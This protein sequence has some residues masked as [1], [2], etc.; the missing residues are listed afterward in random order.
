VA[1]ACVTVFDLTLSERVVGRAIAAEGAT[2]TNEIVL[3]QLASPRL[4]L[5]Q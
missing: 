3:C 2:S 4:V 5:P 1:A